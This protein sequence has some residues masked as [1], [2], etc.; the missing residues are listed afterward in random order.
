MNMSARYRVIYCLN[1]FFGGLG[2]EEKASLP[3]RL[4]KGAKGPGIL[5]Q[6]IFQ[7]MQVTA[8]I[9]FGDNYLA[10]NTATAVQE[11]IA[12]LK[13]CFAA[14]KDQRPH[15]LLAGPAF[16]AGRYGLACGAICTAVQDT[17]KVPA[18]TAMFPQNPAADEYRKKILIIKSDEDVMALEAAVQRM[19]ALGLKLLQGQEPLPEQDGYMPQGRRKNYFAERSGASR[20][21][22]MLLKKLKGEPFATEYPMPV[23]DRVE[24]APAIDDMTR[25]KLALVTSGGI[26]PRGN[27][28]RIA[29]ANAQCFGTYSLAG[30]TELTSETHQTAHGGYDPTFANAN[31]NRVLPLDAV[32]DLEAEGAIGSLHG[33]YYATVG[34]ATSVDSARN[35]GKEIAQKLLKDGVQAVI[36]TST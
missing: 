18:L 2:G 11:I 7:D 32:R 4:I 25:A 27:P 13:P 34:N 23:F 17:F 21:V 33:Y 30:L 1:Q 20:A 31:P 14:G 22:D 28:D 36:L 29:A 16:N 15:L 35:F 8:T 3:P 26:V 9:V 19:G 10:E 24:P 5:L 12:L 6:K